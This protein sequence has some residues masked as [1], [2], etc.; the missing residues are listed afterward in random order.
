MTQRAVRG[1]H[2][3]ST[4]CSVSVYVLQLAVDKIK[5]DYNYFEIKIYKSAMTMIIMRISN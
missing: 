3:L 2:T 4:Q 5:V 1:S